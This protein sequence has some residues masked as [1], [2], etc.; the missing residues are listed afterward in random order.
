MV[1]SGYRRIGLNV[2]ATYGRSLVALVCGLFSTRWVLMALGT[3]DFGLYAVVGSLVAFASFFGS[4]LQTSVARHLAYALGRE[5]E[6]GARRWM[7]AAVAVHVVLAV[8]IV[9]VGWT[10][11]AWVLRL[12]VDMPVA[13]EAAC[14]SVF[15]LSLIAFFAVT[16]G[17][18]F[19]ALFT[20]HQRF[21]EL[22]V[23]GMGQTV[24][25]LGGACWLLGYSGD[26]LVA[27]ALFMCGGTV[28]VQMVQAVWATVKWSLYRSDGFGD[29][30]KV[31]AILGFASWNLFGGG[32]WLIANK[33]SEFVTNRYF[34]LAANAAYGIAVQVQGQA[35]ALAN[36]LVGAFSPA[37]T[38]LRGTG[39]AEGTRK[40]A[41]RSGFWGAVLLALF[42]VPLLAE[43]DTVLQLWLGNPPIGAGAVCAI[44]LTVA[45]CNK[46]TMGQQL[47]IS[48]DGRIASWQVVSGLSQALA[49]PLA[50]VLSARGFGLC[51]AAVAYAAVFAGCLVSN[52]YFGRRIAGIA[53]GTWLRRTVLPLLLVVVPAIAVAMLPRLWMTA[54]LGR[55]VVVSALTT[56]AFALGSIIW[57][58]LT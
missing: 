47:A 31:K 52:L 57:K 21:V 46:V 15:R 28:C 42:A 5:G 41:L 49:L 36:A 8:A 11:G 50:F 56:T 34:G 6:M 51:S 19:G 16:V 29:W 7:C 13:R 58:R 24:Y 17:I 22:A 3:D 39:D 30:D 37:V 35:E 55:V 48:A 32:G 43:M 53:V 20:A 10:V 12:L 54:G 26:R 4:L 25:V 14:L 9:V 1:K 27:Y 45:V 23:L 33:G 38:E 18:P 40:L 2:A 44:L